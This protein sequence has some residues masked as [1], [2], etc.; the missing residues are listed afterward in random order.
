VT[1]PNR[2]RRIGL[3]RAL[4]KNGICSRAQAAR[5]IRQGKVKL[6][7]RL[8]RDPECSVQLSRSNF[9]IAGAAA[10]PPQRSYWMF[11]KPRGVVTTASDEKGRQTVYDLLPADLPWLVPV[12]RLDKASEGLLLF[13]NDS[14][15]AARITDPSSHFD[16]TYHVQIDTVADAELLKTIQIGVR[17]KNGEA[18]SVKH[19]RLL[20]SGHRNCWLEVVLDEG[21]NRQLRRIFEALDVEVLRLVRVAIAGVRLGDLPKSGFRPLSEAEMRLLDRSR[22]RKSLNT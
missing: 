1:P 21:R 12:G 19:A 15:W 8:V 14:E 3:A 4:S 17:V 6:N 2:E 10:A 11:N 7:G 16:K 9:E 5:L 22:H 18:L 13:T 20:R